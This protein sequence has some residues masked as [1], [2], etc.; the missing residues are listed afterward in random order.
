VATKPKNNDKNP[1]R[2]RC[3]TPSYAVDLIVPYLKSDDVVWESAAGEGLLA[4]ALRP[5]VGDVLCTDILTEQNYFD[6][7]AIPEGYTVQITNVPFS[8]KY[9][10]LERA[11]A[12]GKPFALLMPADTLFAATAQELFTEYGFGM[13]L[14]SQR[15]DFKMPNT[16]WKGSAQFTSAWFT[17]KIGVPDGVHIIK[18]DWSEQK[19]L[20]KKGQSA[21][22]QPVKQKV[23][24]QQL[25]MFAEGE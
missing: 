7:R 4:D 24:Y 6:D 14:P 17:W 11:Y 10:W 16:G 13:L 3:Q 8:I 18:V 5:Y 15:I 9:E 19:R 22:I 20:I 1:D 21:P 25:C 12:L 23:L 2:D